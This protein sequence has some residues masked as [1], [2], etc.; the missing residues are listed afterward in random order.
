MGD[1]AKT[2]QVA[3]HQNAMILIWYHGLCDAPGWGPPDE[4]CGNPVQ[5]FHSETMECA[6][7]MII[8]Q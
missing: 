8:C 6:Q 2:N 7:P 1:G 3:N 4:K 5:S